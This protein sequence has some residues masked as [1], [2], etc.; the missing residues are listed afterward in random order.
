MPHPVISAQVCVGPSSPQQLAFPER[1]PAVL[2]CGRDCVPSLERQ[3]SHCQPMTLL[4]LQ[5]TVG[6]EGYCD[7]PRLTGMDVHRA[8]SHGGGGVVWELGITECYRIVI[9]R[10][11]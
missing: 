9:L 11:Q 8:D 10:A 7:G 2:D 1:G 4:S 6:S 5:L 3:S